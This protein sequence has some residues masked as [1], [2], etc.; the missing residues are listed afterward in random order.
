MI[1]LI[2]LIVSSPLLAQGRFKA[3][4]GVSYISN[5]YTAP[6]LYD[7]F[8]PTGNLSYTFFK[9]AAFGLAVENA[10]SL[11]WSGVESETNYKFGFTSSF[12]LLAS[13]NLNKINFY[14]GSGPAYV[15]QV[16]KETSFNERESGY[17]LNTIVGVGLRR[18]SIFE[19]SLS[20]E[21]N[22][23]LSYLKSLSPS[24]PDGGMISFI[25]FFRT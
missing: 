17:Y 22:V 19:S 16:S 14:A 3:G 4:L 5:T 24:M 7:Y 25:V 10:T 1:L 8:A 11:R 6:H 21:Y 2:G 18:K 9:K 15:K 12:P 23:R 13:L 20:P